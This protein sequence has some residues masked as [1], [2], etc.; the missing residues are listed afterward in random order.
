MEREFS[1]EV[2]SWRGPAP[3]HPVTVPEETMVRTAAAIDVGD[4]VAV[5]LSVDV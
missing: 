5:G 3:F 1:G 2:W 4:T